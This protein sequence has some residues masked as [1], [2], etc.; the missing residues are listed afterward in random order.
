M[1]DGNG[2]QS[3]GSDDWLTAFILRD[4]PTLAW[5]L[6]GSISSEDEEDAAE[7]VAT[8]VTA[9]AAA[10]LA[11]AL[12]SACAAASRRIVSSPA[13]LPLSLLSLARERLR[14]GISAAFNGC[15]LVAG[16]SSVVSLA[17]SG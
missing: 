13:L 1:E 2:D 8:P 12:T 14:T 11:A 9:S 3:T 7:E 5:E 10:V 4:S 15:S 6:A 16:T 17:T